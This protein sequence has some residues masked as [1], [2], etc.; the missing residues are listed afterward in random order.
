[1]IS[2][3]RRRERDGFSLLELL[4]VVVILGIITAVLVPHI[5]AGLEG[6]KLATAA[7]TTLQAA[8]Y[9]RTMALLN[10]AEVV[11]KFDAT[12]GKIAVAAGQAGAVPTPNTESPE[13]NPGGTIVFYH[14]ESEEERTHA[15]RVSAAQETA[16]SF[17][18]E[19]S[20]DYECEGVRFVFLGYDDFLEDSGIQAER[21]EEGEPFEIRFRSNGTCRPFKMMVIP[22]DNHPDD[23]YS[24]GIQLSFDVTGAGKAVDV[25]ER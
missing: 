24:G 12:A 8:R 22:N 20:A 6:A 2:P 13:N 25:Q 17:A 4:L 3:T 18:D 21:R 19:V 23:D 1:M 9:A 7:R 14:E 16:Q 15:A 11:L 5:G 10:Q